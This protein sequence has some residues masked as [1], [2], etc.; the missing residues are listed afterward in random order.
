[1]GRV[2]LSFDNGPEPAVTNRVLE[3]LEARGVRT[4]FFVIGQKL[5]IPEYRAVAARAHAQG[6]WIG[7]HSYSHSKALGLLP[8]REVANS[9]ITRTQELI[10]DLAHPMRLFRPAANGGRIDRNLL[11]RAACELLI[12]GQ[13]TC[14]LWNSIPEDWRKPRDWLDRAMADCHAQGWSL[15]V[16]HDLPTGAMDYLAD[17]IDR[18]RAEDTELVQEFPPSCMPIVRGQPTMPLEPYV[19]HAKEPLQHE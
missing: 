5:E 18:L 3:I 11:S 6:H 12:E 14:V 7:N 1:M 10:G 19:A 2:T 9:E 4:T 15:V 13:Y 16:L 17:F 8:S